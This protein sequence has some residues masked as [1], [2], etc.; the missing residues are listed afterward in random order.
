MALLLG[1]DV[2][3][4]A[5]KGLLC[6]ER[7]QVVAE[8]SASHELSRPRAGWSEQEPSLWWRATVE[9]IRR[10]LELAGAASDQVLAL[11]LSGQM[12]G[13]VFLSREALATAGQRAPALRPALLW[14]D[15]RTQRQAESIAERLGSVRA[16]VERV[17][18]APLTGFT[19]PKILW[20]R[21][22]EPELFAHLAAVCLPKDYV[23]L[24]LTGRLAT[25]V[26]D[27]AGT[28]LFD[29]A[30]RRWSSPM[31]EAFE[32]DPALMPEALES[33][34]FAGEL[35]R[36]AAEETGLVRG[37]PVVAG[38][39]DNQCGAI[40]AGVV[41]P[42]QVLATLG[43]S[44]VVYAHSA[45][46][47]ADLPSDPGVPAGRIQAM[48]APDGGASG[49]GHWALTG[50]MLSAAGS[51]QWARQA[52]FGDVSYEQ[53]LLEASEVPAGA[54]GLLFLPHLSGERCPHND[55]SA[56]GA[57]IGLTARHTR[58]H[59][60]RSILEGVALTMRQILDLFCEAGVQPQ[61]VR[62]GGG[63][64]R[65]AVWRQIQAD[66][67]DL[68]CATPTAEQGPAHGAALLAGVGAGV[69]ASVAEAC[70]KAIAISE[71]R[72]PDPDDAARYAHLLGVYRECYPL[73]SPT[74][75]VLGAAP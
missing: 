33:G 39:G 16:V 40:G 1:V 42:G 62:L 21:E 31:F 55:P 37:T 41:E 36:F 14:N 61:A 3:T 23:R 38:S 6:D 69:W 20:L 53:L 73:L 52:L 66:V 45:A 34:R 47:R 72:E 30:E 18:N 51:L 71:V 4:S 29:V 54:E 70:R 65:S 68:P 50:C 67:Y 32:L 56:R 19:L 22:T 60:V 46:Y 58:A 74:C 75:E 59:L 44:G 11:G 57:W 63:G 43:T 8:A 15:Q 7:G 35:T 5:T 49:P 25:D 64:A 24:R 27:A 17:G 28:L 9:V 48:C 2:G 26:G 10:V 13:S 12:H